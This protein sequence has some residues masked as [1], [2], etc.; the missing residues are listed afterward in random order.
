MTKKLSFTIL[1]EHGLDHYGLTQIHFESEGFY[2]Y[3]RCKFG[4]CSLEKFATEAESKNLDN[5]LGRVELESEL[6]NSEGF[7]DVYPQAHYI[8][9]GKLLGEL[10][11]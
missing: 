9:I 1:H 11:K 7:L 5:G 3:Y 2:Y 6:V 8:I 10:E 4:S